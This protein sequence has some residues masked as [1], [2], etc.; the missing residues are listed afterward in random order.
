MSDTEPFTLEQSYDADLGTLELRILETED[1]GD[2]QAQLVTGRPVGD[3]AAQSLF[4]GLPPGKTYDDK[5]LFGLICGSAL[6]GVIDL[7]RAWPTETSWTLGL[8]M[9]D[10]DIRGRGVGKAVVRTLEAWI[11]SQG[12]KVMRIGVVERNTRAISFWER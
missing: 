9:L 5:F 6:V 8:L 4:S 2:L 1:G 7:L 3:A 10:P 12:A 11:R